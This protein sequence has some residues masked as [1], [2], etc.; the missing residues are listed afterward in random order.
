MVAARGFEPTNLT[1]IDPAQGLLTVR[2]NPRSQDQ[3]PA[4]RTVFGRL[5]DSRKRP[6]AGAKVEITGFKA[7]NGTT[8]GRMPEG[9]DPVT[10][11]DSSGEFEA[12][13][14]KDC[15][16]VDLRIDATGVSRTT[17]SAVPLGTKRREFVLSEG[18][19]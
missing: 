8:W 12:Y 14:A 10:V 6:V 16:A 2:L 4:K 19:A 7:G 3:L 17:L 15:D 18:G 11:S 13:I 5:L 9:T 1:K